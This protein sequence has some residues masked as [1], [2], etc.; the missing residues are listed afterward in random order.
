MD[1]TCDEG[2][3]VRGDAALR[4]NVNPVANRAQSDATAQPDHAKRLATL[5]A[6]CVLVGV[7][8][9]ETTDD[10]DCSAY[11]VSRGA[12]T[13]QFDDLSAVE[14]WLDRVGGQTVVGA[15]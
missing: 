4:D 2:R 3:I 9:H 5:Q 6:Q 7:V 13:R 12:L 10:H 11:V 15:T 1:A 14:S 8:L